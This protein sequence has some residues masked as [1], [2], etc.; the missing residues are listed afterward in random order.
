MALN[1][2]TSQAGLDLIKAFE[3]FR[4]RSEL[5]PNGRWMVGYGHV[6]RAKKGVR[7][8]KTEAEAILR[9]YDLPPVER[10]VM[11]C[12]LA[13]MTQN[14]FD[15]LVSLAFNI[16]PKA[17][18]GSDVV[19][20]MNAG[21]RLE[22]A[23]AFD[24]WRRAKIGGRVQI[25]DALVRRRAAEKALF[26]NAPGRL[27][28]ASSR[29]YRAMHDADALPAPPPQREILVEHHSAP[30]LTALPEVDD[31][32]TVRSAT[33]AAAESVRQQMV[34]I[35]GEEGVTPQTESGPEEGG[36]T[37]EEIAAAVSELAGETPLSG[38]S[39]SVWPSRTDLPEVSDEPAPRAPF[40]PDVVGLEPIE[41]SDVIDD[42][43]PVE[44]S[45]E[46]IERAVE[47]N[48]TIDAE[49]RRGTF[50]NALPFGLLALI[51]AA[52]GGYGL[53]SQFGVVQSDQTIESPMAVFMPPFLI[54]LGVLLFAVMAYYFIRSLSSQ[55]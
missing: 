28:I 18:S 8:N 20:G 34:R 12:V 24:L 43:E 41:G 39:K 40:E 11:R 21:N 51:G 27:P 45:E 29:L 46:S 44:V 48:Q 6:R 35:L 42:L 3:G 25:V 33:E 9:E 31:S 7:V 16:G 4:A 1:M 22:A 10:F 5:L 17:F 52:L 53:A 47:L 14:E 55:D 50:L 30:E 23:A 13:P 49:D 54:L 19:A 37:A 32:E 2:R 26:L 36:T 15:A 38:V